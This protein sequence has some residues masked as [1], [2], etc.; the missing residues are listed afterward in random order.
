M[1]SKTL[2]V[3]IVAKNDEDKISD[4]LE[5]V[6]WAQEIILVNTGSVDGTISIAKKYKAQIVNSLSQKLE[7]SKWRTDGLLAA[8]GDWVFYLD[9]DERATP[10]LKDEILTVLN[11]REYSGFEIPRRNFYLG[12]EMHYGGAWP[13][14]VKRLFRREKLIRWERELHENPVLKGKMSRLQN[15]MIHITHRDLSSM[16]EKTR[17]WSKIEA[18]LLYKANHPPVVWWRFFRIMLTEFWLRAIKQQGWRDGTVGWIG[19]IFQMFSRFFT[20]ARL[21]EMQQTNKKC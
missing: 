15:P 4:C 17:L 13:D 2:S 3:I 14:Y 20:Y 1:K 11:T 8:K 7:F 6:K 5:S 12:K 18:E 16:V 10:E 9:T 19:V 21:W